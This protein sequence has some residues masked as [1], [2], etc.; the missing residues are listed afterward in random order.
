[1]GF[2]K[3]LETARNPDQPSGLPYMS[4]QHA[5]ERLRVYGYE[6]NWNALC[7][8]C[9]VSVHDGRFSN[10]AFLAAAA[11]LEKLHV[12][13]HQELEAYNKLRLAEKRRGRRIPDA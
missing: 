7:D 1:M 10:E 6:D 11:F 13:R 12:K 4:L 9:G 8:I 3:Y 5:L 2:A